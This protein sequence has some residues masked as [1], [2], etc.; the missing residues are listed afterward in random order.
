MK[1]P[2]MDTLGL[3]PDKIGIRTHRQ[4]TGKIT[5]ASTIRQF[6]DLGASA[7]SAI[8][9]TNTKTTATPWRAL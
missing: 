9:G 2:C 1:T 8:S 3:T 4:N 6:W 7:G 5:L